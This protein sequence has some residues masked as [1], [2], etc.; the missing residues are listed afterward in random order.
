MFPALPGAVVLVAAVPL[1]LVGY[2]T[3]PAAS[4][5]VGYPPLALA[6]RGAYEA[7]FTAVLLVMVCQGFR[8]AQARR[9]DPRPRHARYDLFHPR[10]LYAVL[11][12]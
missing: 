12:A 2:V 9:P 8:P 1:T 11:A 3:D 7:F 6:L 10:P 5:I 4:G